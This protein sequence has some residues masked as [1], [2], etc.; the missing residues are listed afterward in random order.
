MK[1]APTITVGGSASAAPEKQR[2]A[3]RRIVNDE[4]RQDKIGNKIVELLQKFSSK[5]ED[6]IAFLE[7]ILEKED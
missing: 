3:V 1:A 7:S 5:S 6:R 2:Q 4:Q